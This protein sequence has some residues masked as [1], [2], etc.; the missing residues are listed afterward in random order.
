MF[1]I[2]SIEHT[3]ESSNFLDIPVLFCVTYMII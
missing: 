3:I 1:E 2:V